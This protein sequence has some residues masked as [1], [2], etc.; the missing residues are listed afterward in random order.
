MGRCDKKNS[1][2]AIRR[3][4]LGQFRER[5]LNETTAIDLQVYLNELAKQFA[6]GA[7]SLVRRHLTAI[8]KLA[9]KSDYLAKDP[10]EE[11]KMPKCF[12]QS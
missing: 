7:V 5:Q 8:F 11:L 10:A 4:I 12:E 1:G 3:Y 6:K 9:R 2:F